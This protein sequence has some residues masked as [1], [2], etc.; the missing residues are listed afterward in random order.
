M[1]PVGDVMVPVGDVRVPVVDVTESAGDL[2]VSG[3]DVIIPGGDLIIV[4]GDVIM[5][6][7]SIGR[8]ALPGDGEA[9]FG[10]LA[11][12]ENELLMLTLLWKHKIYNMNSCT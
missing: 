4:R 7:V 6:A 9:V 10:V 3:G 2:T 5:R 12:L 11:S 1:V 8:G